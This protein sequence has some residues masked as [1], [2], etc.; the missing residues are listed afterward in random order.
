VSIRLLQIVTARESKKQV[1][2]QNPMNTQRSLLLLLATM[3]PALLV[4]SSGCSKSDTDQAK[5]SA[6][7]A[8]ADVKATASQ[9]WES[10]KDFTY[11]QR[12]NFSSAVDKMS[13]DLDQ[14][15]AEL[16]A[17]NGTLSDAAAKDRDAAL[18]DYDN[19]RA[20][21]KADLIALDNSTADTWADAKA[22]VADAWQRVKAAYDRAM[23]S[24]SAS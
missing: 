19:A 14:K 16:K 12:A 3:S 9:T 21:L 23:K 17:K 11:E 5:A 1:Q 10:V 22:K 8:I 4:L 15:T 7:N 20:D 18:K 24:D 13:A 2:Q 6:N